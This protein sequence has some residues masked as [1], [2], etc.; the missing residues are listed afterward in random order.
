MELAVKRTCILDAHVTNHGSRIIVYVGRQHRI[1]FIITLV[2]HCCK[3]VQVCSCAQFVE[4]FGVGLLVFRVRFS[5]GFRNTILIRLS[6]CS[7]YLVAES[8]ITSPIIIGYAVRAGTDMITHIIHDGFVNAGHLGRGKPLH[9]I[10]FIN[11]GCMVCR[12]KLAFGVGPLVSFSTCNIQMTRCDKR[13]KGMLV[14][15]QFLFIIG[16]LCE[17][18]AEPV[19]ETFGNGTYRFS[20]LTLGKGCTATSRIV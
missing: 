18:L 4:T 19:G 1:D 17:I 20:E 2:H 11:G 6:F 3:P 9:A 16:I 5:S 12:K 7:I 8:Q 14:K 10:K 15:R 13:K